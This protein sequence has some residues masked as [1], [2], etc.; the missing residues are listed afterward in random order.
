MNYLAIVGP[1]WIW[2]PR[3]S[4]LRATNW[5]LTFGVWEW[6]SLNSSL[7]LSLSLQLHWMNWYR[8]SKRELIFFQS[9][10]RCLCYALSTWICVF[11]IMSKTDNPFRIWL[12]IPLL[13]TK[14]LGEV[15][16]RRIPWCQNSQMEVNLPSEYWYLTIILAK[17]WMEWNSTP[18]PKYSVVIW[19][20]SRSNLTR[21]L[22]T[23]TKKLRARR[24]FSSTASTPI[25]LKSNPGKLMKGLPSP[26]L[27]YPFLTLMIVYF[28]K[29]LL[30][31]LLLHSI[32]GR[33]AECL[34]RKA[35][36][37]NQIFRALKS[38]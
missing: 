21:I 33:K 26:L 36:D 30:S 28:R 4:V 2:L 35:I 29:I 8:M 24:T 14:K 17:S 3:S 23:K 34:C 20:V 31:V 1:L 6:L 15:I 38:F 16:F 37:C 9:R 13:Q 18:M 10:Q 12:N 11:S 19:P 32:W 25:F 27:K 22:T 7:D 5:K